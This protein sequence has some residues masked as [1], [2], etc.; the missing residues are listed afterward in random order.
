MKVDAGWSRLTILLV[1]FAEGEKRCRGTEENEGVSRGK[2]LY[3]GLYDDLAPAVNLSRRA[4]SRGL[5]RS[6]ELEIGVPTHLQK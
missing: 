2:K 1:V 3:I 6:S 4:G 5:C